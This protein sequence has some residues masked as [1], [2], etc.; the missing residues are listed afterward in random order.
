MRKVQNSNSNGG[1]P[2]S[3]NQ[4]SFPK[5]KPKQTK[6]PTNIKGNKRMMQK[7]VT[8]KQSRTTNNSPAG[9]NRSI[10]SSR[11][12]DLVLTVQTLDN[13]KKQAKND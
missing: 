2:E 12:Q 4:R 10:R 5:M 7:T 13:K 9:S 3:K 11:N 1:S 8:I 6:S